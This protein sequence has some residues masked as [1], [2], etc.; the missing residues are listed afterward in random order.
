VIRRAIRAHPP[1]R[2]YLSAPKP[3]IPAP[4]VHLGCRPDGLPGEEFSSPC[5]ENKAGGYIG[6][7]A[8]GI[9]IGYSA[10]QNGVFT[11]EQHMVRQDIINFPD[12]SHLT[13]LKPALI[14]QSNKELLY[15]IYLY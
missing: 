9:K 1:A 11:N 8:N 14:G 15:F 10:F 3:A 7:I 6:V 2:S 12:R 5:Q 4:R 13:R